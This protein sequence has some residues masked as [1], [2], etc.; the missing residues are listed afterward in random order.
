MCSTVAIDGDELA[1]PFEYV[2][3]S[4]F[5]D[6][7]DIE[8]FKNS[9]NIFQR[10]YTIHLPVPCWLMI[11]KKKTKIISNVPNPFFSCTMGYIEILI[12][13]LEVYVQSLQTIATLYSLHLIAK[14]S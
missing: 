13:F 4:D 8:V 5:L 7:L 9:Y 2:I 3:I 1:H 6:V 10:K 11:M 14:G 12:S